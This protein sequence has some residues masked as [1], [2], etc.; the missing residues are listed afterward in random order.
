MW[1]GKGSLSGRP[2]GPFATPPG[3][4]ALNVST[5]SAKGFRALGRSIPSPAPR[6]TPSSSGAWQGSGW[7]PR[8]FLLDPPLTLPPT[9][10]P[11]HPASVFYQLLLGGQRLS[12]LD[13]SSARLA[14]RRWKPGSGRADGIFQGGK[15]VQIR[16]V[17]LVGRRCLAQIAAVP[18]PLLIVRREGGG[19]PWLQLTFS[20]TRTSNR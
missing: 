15:R 18:I 19:P 11:S 3:G 16:G 8:G 6:P 9:G 5:G 12:C 1:K 17:S 13:F 2:A 7:L 14:P 20:D 10:P 4:S